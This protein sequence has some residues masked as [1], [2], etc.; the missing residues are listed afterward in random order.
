MYILFPGFKLYIT[1]GMV[2]CVGDLVGIDDGET[3]WTDDLSDW[4]KTVLGR[5]LE[6]TSVVGRNTFRGRRET[7]TIARLLLLQKYTR[8][9][10]GNSPQG[11]HSFRSIPGETVDQL[12]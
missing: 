4:E 2:V 7:S 8:R 9:I 6:I 12:D 3:V 5:K 10:V 1:C 11:N